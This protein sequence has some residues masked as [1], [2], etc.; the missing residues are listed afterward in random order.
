M[1]EKWQKKEDGGGGGGHEKIKKFFR[2][3]KKRITEKI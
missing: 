3:I 2:E 1:L